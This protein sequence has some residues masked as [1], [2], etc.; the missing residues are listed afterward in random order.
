M[1]QTLSENGFEKFRKKTRK[2]QFLEEMETL[3]LWKEL[4]RSNQALLSPIQRER[5]VPSDDRVVP[6]EQL[7]SPIQRERGVP[8]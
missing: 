5:G 4:G 7:L 3:I 2:E 6:R 8:R 1:Q